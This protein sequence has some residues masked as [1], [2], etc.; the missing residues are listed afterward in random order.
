MSRFWQLVAFGACVVIVGFL[1]TRYNSSGVQLS[2]QSAQLSATGTTNHFPPPQDNYNKRQWPPTKT[3]ISEVME[4]NIQM[5]AI[6]TGSHTERK[7]LLSCLFV[8]VS[9]FPLPVEALLSKHKSKADYFKHAMSLTN[10]PTLQAKGDMPILNAT[11]LSPKLESLHIW[12]IGDSIIRQAY[13]SWTRQGLGGM[14]RMKG[15]KG[16]GLLSDVVF[17]L[18]LPSSWGGHATH[19]Q[20]VKV[21]VFAGCYIHSWFGGGTFWHDEFA[22][23]GALRSSFGKMKASLPNWTIVWIGPS[24]VDLPLA[25]LPPAKG[26]AAYYTKLS[27]RAPLFVTI[28]ENVTRDFKVPFVNR[29][30]MEIRYRGLHCDG[31]HTSPHAATGAADWG[32]PGFK[33]LDDLVVQSA[34]FAACREDTFAFC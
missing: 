11:C 30:A 24:F 3:G 15:W 9:G 4:H 1:Q 6:A 32:C 7:Q 28:D 22:R 10:H 12:F 2:V 13:E 14:A 34:L 8:N 19:G 20:P 17:E 16:A 26:D 18:G 29:Y 23:A 21:V 31:I 25:A 33:A 27:Q 5:D